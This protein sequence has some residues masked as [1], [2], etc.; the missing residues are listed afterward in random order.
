MKKQLLSFYNTVLMIVSAFSLCCLLSSCPPKK[1]VQEPQEVE[2][3]IPDETLYSVEIVLTQTSSYCG[4]AAPPQ[5]LL[6]EL[7]TPKPLGGVEYFIRKGKT[8]VVTD[9]IV[10]SGTST[11]NGFISLMLPEGTYCLV[12]AN[13]VDRTTY[14]S[15]YNQLKDGNANNTPVDKACLDKWLSAPEFVFSPVIGSTQ[16]RQLNVHQP[17]SWDATPCTQ[18]MGPLPP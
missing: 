3:G 11:E 5:Y 9:P 13:K 4:G 6:D 18:Y 16:A 7:A 15:I 17:C 14:D 1:V 8:N 12:F 2:E 10:T